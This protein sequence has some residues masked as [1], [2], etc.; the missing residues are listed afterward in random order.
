MSQQLCLGSYVGSHTHGFGNAKK[1]DVVFTLRKLLTY[2]AIDF[3]HCA[4]A[5]TQGATEFL[6][7][8]TPTYFVRGTNLFSL[9]LSN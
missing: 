3:H 5:V 4:I 1:K 7:H 9:K 8:A 6:K 2:K